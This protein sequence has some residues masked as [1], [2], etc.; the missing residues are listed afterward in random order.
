M[1]TGAKLPGIFHSSPA[2]A[3]ALYITNGRVHLFNGDDCAIG[4]HVIIQRHTGSGQPFIACVREILQQVGSTNHANSQP[5]G[6]LLQTVAHD[7]KS[8]RLQMPRLILQDEWSFVPLSV[9]NLSSF[10]LR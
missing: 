4:Q 3:R 7:E 10:E 2:N 5:D 1:L 8:T 9:R 6:L